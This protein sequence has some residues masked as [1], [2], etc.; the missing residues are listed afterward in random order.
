M[1]EGHLKGHFEKEN[2]KY[3]KILLT[4]PHFETLSTSSIN[5]NFTFMHLQ[6]WKVWNMQPLDCKA[7][8]CSQIL[9]G[10]GDQFVITSL[11]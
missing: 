11:V 9:V 4:Q 6:G 10:Q 5:F 1:R 8:F 7:N 3:F 2:K